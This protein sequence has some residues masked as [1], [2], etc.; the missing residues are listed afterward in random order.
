MVHD[1]QEQG[2]GGPNQLL[3]P[4]WGRLRGV[5]AAVEEVQQ[6]GL[7]DVVAVV[8]Q[9]DLGEAVFLGIRVQRAAAQP[10]G[11]RPRRC[12]LSAR[13]PRTQH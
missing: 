10:A 5:L 12:A 8:A 6:E 4:A 7:D 3:V 1:G 9:R 11:C 13:R 2:Q